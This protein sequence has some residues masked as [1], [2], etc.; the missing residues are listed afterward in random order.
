MLR[1]STERARLADRSPS[2][3]MPICASEEFLRCWSDN[4]GWFASSQFILPFFITRKG[5]FKQLV[6]T[7]DT[8][9]QCGGSSLADE[10]EF[11]NDVLTLAKKT[12]A[13]FIAQPRTTCVFRTA[14]DGSTAVE[15]GSYR[16]DLSPSK[17]LLFKSMHRHHRRVIRKGMRDGV[18]I[19]SGPE[20]LE[21]CYRLIEETLEREQKPCLPKALLQNFER[22][23]G[24]GVSFYVAFYQGEPHASALLISDA[25]RSYYLVGGR[26]SGAY[27]GASAVLHWAA[28]LDMK[29]RG[30]S[31][32]DFVG[33]RV[34]PVSGSK[35]E[36]LQV[37][38]SRFGAQFHKGLL[39][40]YPLRPAHYR[41]ARAGNRVKDL[42]NGNRYN[43]DMIDNEMRTAHLPRSALIR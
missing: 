25:D 17:E 6:I 16:V 30:V 22:Q 18:A 31:A 11:L 13:H 4:Y 36:G 7:T 28:M 38:K 23:L 1:Q 14:P 15:W 24:E 39:W 3:E 37:F 12:D 8:L 27:N 43:E 32:Y 26:R 21:T 33:G 5:V 40:K 29:D 42:L 20:Q 34:S 10:R 2:T 9:F 41:F 19:K 35:Q